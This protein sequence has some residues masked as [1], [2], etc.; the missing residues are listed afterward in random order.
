MIEKRTILLFLFFSVFACFLP[1][2]ERGKASYYAKNLHG[3]KMASGM[4]YH[5]DSLTCAH[6]FLPFGTKLKVKNLSNGKEVVVSVQDRGPHVGGR[7]IDLSHSAAAQLG[8][9]GHGVT[10]VE[11]S[12]YHGPAIKVPFAAIDSLPMVDFKE[13]ARIEEEVEE[14]EE[15]LPARKLRR[16][17]TQ[18]PSRTTRQKK[19]FFSEEFMQG[20]EETAEPETKKP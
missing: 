7:I 16:M 12:F 9:L 3:R 20:E 15:V 11:V 10:T 5:R 1:A 6:P 18:Q 8:M 13:A 4:R 2:Q 17:I 19:L 14:E